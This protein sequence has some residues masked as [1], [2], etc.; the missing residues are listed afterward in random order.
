MTGHD[1]IVR[2]LRD[3]HN[4]VEASIAGL[5][6][7]MAEARA[8]DASMT[9]RE[10]VAHLAEAAIAATASFE[11]REHAWGSYEPEDRSWDG[12]KDAFRGAFENAMSEVVQKP[13]EESAILHAHDYLVAHNYYHVGQICA[14][15]R[16]VQPDWDTYAI[17]APAKA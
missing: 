12:V 2:Q 6:A 13:E 14:A 10:S 1:L 3:A 4:Q 7:E 16:T 9:I 8:N 11:G 15:R 17:Y 5:D